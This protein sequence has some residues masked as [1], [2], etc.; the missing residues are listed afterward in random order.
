MLKY[1]LL[2]IH[3]LCISS[4]AQ[5]SLGKVED[6][7]KVDEIQVV[8]VKK[9]EPE[10]VTEK[11]SLKEGSMA[12]NYSIREAIKSIYDLKYFEVVEAHHIKKDGKNVLQFKVKEKPIVSKI[13]FEG[14]DEVSSEDLKEQIKTREFNILD[15]NT[16]KADVSKVQDFYEEKGFFLANVGYELVDNSLGGVDLK[17]MIREFDKVRVK[18]IMF[19]GN[20]EIK[21]DELKSFMQTR[22]ESLFSPLSGSGNFKEFNFK[23]DVE[24]L[25][26]LYKTRGYL[27]VN[28]GNPSITVSEDKKWIF[29]TIKVNEGPK[30]SINNIFYNGE[31]L[32]TENEMREKTQ[33]KSG[34]IYSEETLRQDIQALTEMYQDK[35]YAFA[36]VLRTLQM[37]PGENKV[38]IN[39]SFE[40]GEIAYFGKIIIKG[41]T[42]TRDKVVRR[43]LKIYEGMMYSGSLLRKSKENVVRLGFFEPASVVFNTVSPKGSNNVLNVEISVKER[44]TGQI[45]VGAGYSTATKGFFQASVSQNNFRGLGQNLNLNVSLAENQKTYNLGFTEP[46]FLDTKWT[47]GGDIYRTQSGLIS[48][49]SSE[50]YGGDVRVGYPIFEYTRLFMT[51]RHEV[52]NIQNVRNPTVDEDIENGTAAT[53]QMSLRLDKRNNIF[54]PSD[55]HFGSATLEYAGFYGDQKWLKASLEGR[56]YE[57]I[58]EELVFRSRVRAE[59]LMKTSDRALPRTEKFQLGGARNMR[60]YDFEDVGPKELLEDEI[61]GEERLFNI[62]GQFSLLTTLELEH[63]LIKEAGL[64]WVVFYDAGNVFETSLG[65]D[66]TLRQD[67][68]FGFRWFSPIGVLRFE[69]GYPIDPEEGQDGQQFHF[70]IGQLF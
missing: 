22:E 46:Y 68:G 54:E 16:V 27:Q 42:K 26:Y 1:I 38:D 13:I 66:F 57:P 48:S 50:K 55:G 40:K 32:F 60:G 45:S 49:F 43:E 23:N 12:T 65:D 56:Y 69:F 47:A 24:R 36:N 7:F 11:V 17:F 2:S 53:V 58:Y 41:N 51:L 59:Q 29:I 21:D 14:N 67:Y 62:G 31:L 52:T 19:L 33:L 20:N 8:G 28:I 4:F 44:Q 18:R 35:G 30:F 15:V 39:Y 64:K 34:D 6:F 37:V 70:D 61:S 3:L 9:V 63:P 10:A 5:E 25:K